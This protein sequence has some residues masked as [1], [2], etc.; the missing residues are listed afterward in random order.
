[1]N[2]RCVGDGG[3]KER[4]I[5]VTFWPECQGRWFTH[6]LRV[7]QIASSPQYCSDFLPALYAKVFLATD[8]CIYIASTFWDTSLVNGESWTWLGSGLR[9]PPPLSKSAP[10][11]RNDVGTKNRPLKPG[12]D[13]PG[14]FPSVGRC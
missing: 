12:V 6:P 8:K 3:M 13:V 7:L 1:M 9:F 4:G 14:V 5:K 10:A 2:W 11:D